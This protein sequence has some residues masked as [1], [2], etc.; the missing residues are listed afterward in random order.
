MALLFYL[1]YSKLSDMKQTDRQWHDWRKLKD[2]T[3]KSVCACLLEVD[4]LEVVSEMLSKIRTVLHNTS[5]PIHDVLSSHRSR[6][7]EELRLPKG[8]TE[9]HRKSNLPVLKLLHLMHSTVHSALV[10]CFYI[11]YS[12]F[13][14][15]GCVKVLQF[16]VQCQ[17]YIF[18]ICILLDIYI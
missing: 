16:R 8:T 4:S 3:W 12:D 15:K 17:S 2:R 5:H 6:F 14:C 11:L 7:S 10:T 9:Q 13:H 18:I 1:F